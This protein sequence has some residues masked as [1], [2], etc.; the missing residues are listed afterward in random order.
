MTNTPSPF[1]KGANHDGIVDTWTRLFGTVYPN[2][3]VVRRSYE[4]HHA[5]VRELFADKPDQLLT[6]KIQSHS[7][8][9]LR[10]FLELPIP[11]K[12]FPRHNRGRLGDDVGL[13]L[14]AKDVQ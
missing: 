3:N 7:W 4:R 14:T 6:F 5:E 11:Q 1:V 13:H 12:P 10:Q 8:D 9:E 2:P